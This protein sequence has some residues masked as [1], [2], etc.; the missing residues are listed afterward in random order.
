M[1]KVDL[2]AREWCD[3]VFAGRNK[4][5]GAYRIRANAGKRNGRAFFILLLAIAAIGAGIFVNNK[6][7][8]AI[9][10][11]M[12][13]GQEITQM[14]RIQKEE[15]KEEEKKVEKQEEPE[16]E[17]AVEKVAV[18]ASIQFTVPDIVDDSKVVKEKEL[19]T[20]DEVTK[21][22]F[23]IASQTYAGDAKGG[24]NIDDLK[25][26]QSTGG[27]TVPPK[28][29]EVLDNEIVEQPAQFPG[30]ESALIAYVAKNVKY[31]SIALEQDLQGTV[32]LKFVVE[33]DG[34]I[35][36]VTVFKS[37]SKECDREAMRVI[38][39]LPRFT[40]ARMQGRTVPVAYKIPVRYVLQ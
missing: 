31:P 34:S 24:I 32:W 2:I 13:D 16:P 19:K 8:E 17:Q 1:A 12:D 23:A 25:E 20:Q 6:I 40:P 11:N 30:G 15:K 14:S 3:M 22:N 38:K 28:K 39:S 5:Y 10:A 35:G 4:E 26:N 7:Q 9:A 21:S 36:N 37:L 27:T 18:K 33:K 29:E